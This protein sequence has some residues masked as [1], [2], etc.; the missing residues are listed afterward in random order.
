MA[1]TTYHCPE[2]DRLHDDPADAVYAL[3][4]VCTDC[5]LER[6]LA[7]FARAPQTDFVRAA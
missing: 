3:L 4:V 1:E 7:A 2:C 6:D 5:A